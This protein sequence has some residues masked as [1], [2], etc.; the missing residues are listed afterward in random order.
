MA[1][2]GWGCK[3]YSGKW[4]R[5]A[6][7]S[8]IFGGLDRGRPIKEI[9][10]FINGQN[11]TTNFIVVYNE[12]PPPPGAI[13]TAH[14]KPI[15][16]YFPSIALPAKDHPVSCTHKRHLS[17]SF[18]L[19]IALADCCGCPRTTNENP[20]IHPLHWV[21]VTAHTGCAYCLLTLDGNTFECAMRL[22]W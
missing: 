13:V 22:K 12:Q 7:T 19:M 9:F 10:G 21:N 17:T 5:Q 6:D 18:D 14:H 4:N 2:G 11:L 3:K 1:L 20:R 8:N 16:V 15:S